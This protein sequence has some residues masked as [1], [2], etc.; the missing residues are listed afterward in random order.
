MTQGGDT[1][2][3][4]VQH[5]DA[6]RAQIERFIKAIG[7]AT[8]LNSATQRGLSEMMGIKVGTLT[9]YLRGEVAP[10]RVGLGIQAALAD[11]LGVTLDALVG[12]YL[13]GEYAT[14]LSLHAVESWIRSDAGQRD[15]PSIMA[16]LQEAGKRWLQNPGGTSTEQEEEDPPPW[17]WPLDELRDAGVSDRFRE[18][19]GLTD[20]RMNALV[21][22]GEF[23]ED[24]IEAFSVACNYDMDAVREAFEER[25][26][27]T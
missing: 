16:S 24:L 11:V 14:G 18:R 22:R 9:K 20:E 19:M 3:Q 27:V 6:E 7:H 13:T 4:P 5:S 25:Q 23:D 10:M 17:N 2:R 1:K 15:L 21:L 8:V 26:P 12:Y